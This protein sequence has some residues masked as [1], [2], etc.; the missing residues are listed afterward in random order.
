M[1]GEALIVQVGD[2]QSAPR[3]HI[4]SQ[5]WCCALVILTSWRER[6]AGD[7]AGQ[8]SQPAVKLVHGPVRDT[9]T[10]DGDLWLHTH[11]C[12]WAHTYTHKVKTL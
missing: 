11:T 6:E 10:S 2:L 12:V 7:P 4:K 3:T 9:D 1:V 5:A 8:P